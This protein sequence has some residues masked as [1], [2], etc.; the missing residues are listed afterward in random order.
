VSTELHARI[1]IFSSECGIKRSA[2]G[3]RKQV[4]AVYAF[5]SFENARYSNT[6][7]V[8]PTEI[9]DTRNTATATGLGRLAHWRCGVRASR[10]SSSSY[11]SISRWQARLNHYS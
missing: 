5:F 9:W 8:G 11:T 2:N 1:V 7:D 4:V 6:G 3:K 10:H